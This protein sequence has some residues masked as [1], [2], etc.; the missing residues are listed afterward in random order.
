MK[1]RLTQFV[2]YLLECVIAFQSRRRISKSRIDPNQQCFACGHF[3]GSISYDPNSKFVI[4]QCGVCNAMRAVRPILPAT[5]WDFIGRD[6]DQIKQ[7]EMEM[8]ERFSG[9]IKLSEKKSA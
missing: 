2:E 4:H 1:E 5:Q 7:Y 3:Q 9:L 6:V 8:R